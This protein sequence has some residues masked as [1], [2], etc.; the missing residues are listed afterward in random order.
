MDQVKFWRDKR[1][2]MR[3]A[4]QVW[5][6]ATQRWS[7]QLGMKVVIAFGPCLALAWKEFKDVFMWATTEHA[8]RLVAGYS[9]RTI[10]RW[11]ASG[12]VIG[13][14]VGTT[15]YVNINSLQEY[16][17][18]LPKVEASCV[19]C[20][21]VA[22]TLGVTERTVQRWA[23]SGKI[24]GQVVKSALYIDPTSVGAG[25]YGG[26]NATQREEDKDN[27]VVKL[28]SRACY[29]RSFCRGDS[30]LCNRAAVLL[31]AVGG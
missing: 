27:R 14:M 5:R 8:E 9:V 17:A 18:T 22:Q 1:A 24:K 12:K 2:L 16:V 4:R 15:Y 28:A 25:L 7:S 20:R 30:E 10:R 23:A 11:L 3:R 21:V 19:P 26:L 6:A 13:V 29:S 31:R